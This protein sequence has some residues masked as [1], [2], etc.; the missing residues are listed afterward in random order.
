MVQNTGRYWALLIG[1]ALVLALLMSGLSKRSGEHPLWGAAFLLG[2][3]LYFLPTAVAIPRKWR[4][5]DVAAVF[6]W[7]LVLGWTI[8]GWFIAWGLVFSPEGP[9]PG[10]PMGKA[11]R[12]EVRG[13]EMDE[14]G[15][16]MVAGTAR[17]N[18]GRPLGNVRL[19]MD[20]YDASGNVVG[21]A[22]ARI[23]SL[24]SYATWEFRTG[25]AEP[26]AA[27]AALREFYAE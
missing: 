5:R 25:A 26:R 7:N 9:W 8:L 10:A 12:V 16:R 23:V 24:D 18:F 3:F 15:N 17:N 20:L 1:A 19:L 2:T 22:A 14:A 4:R 11:L 27:R 6:T 21:N 13:L